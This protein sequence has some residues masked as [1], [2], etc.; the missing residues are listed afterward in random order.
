M[1]EAESNTGRLARR[2]AAD[3]AGKAGAV[4]HQPAWCASC[5]LI[6]SVQRT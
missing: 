1:D 4:I 3:G 5:S 6:A 2:V